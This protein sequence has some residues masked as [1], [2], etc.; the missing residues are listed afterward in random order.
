M[1]DF[2]D[3]VVDPRIPRGVPQGRF[4]LW[5]GVGGGVVIGEVLFGNIQSDEMYNIVVFFWHLSFRIA[6][7]IL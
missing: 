4:G 1:L 2:G 3:H 5:H 7:P 6:S